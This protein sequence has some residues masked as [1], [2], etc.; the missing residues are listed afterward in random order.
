VLVVA[1]VVATSR[2]VTLLERASPAGRLWVGGA[3]ALA[4]LTALGWVGIRLAEAASRDSASRTAAAVVV[5]VL[6]FALAALFAARR[7]F[8]QRRALAIVGPPAL[9][10]IAAFGF[11]VLRDPPLRGA[12]EQRAPL[13]A[14]LADLVP[15]S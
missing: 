7:S 8:V 4:G 15:R 9:V 6:A 14:P 3:A 12:I 11:V 1:V 13:F 2:V 5:D 10:A